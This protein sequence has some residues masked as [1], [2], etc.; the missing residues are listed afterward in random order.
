MP[1]DTTN[2]L[3]ISPK[4]F[5]AQ[6]D[7]VLNLPAFA[8]ALGRE[9]GQR[10]RTWQGST[11]TALRSI[12]GVHTGGSLRLYSGCI[13]FAHCD[14]HSCDFIFFSDAHYDMIMLGVA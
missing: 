1:F 14:T 3:L 13:A 9:L 6:K 2:D 4:L 12:D 7:T 10:W 11:W 5:P 8:M